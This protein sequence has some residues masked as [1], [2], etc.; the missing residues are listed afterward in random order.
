MPPPDLKRL[1]K[2]FGETV[3]QLRTAAGLSQMKLAEKADLTHNFVGEI[4]RGEKLVSLET[5]AR[6][7]V[8]FGLDGAELLAKAKI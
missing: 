2:R 8:A 4:E 3:R 6:L 1:P 7:A 5:I